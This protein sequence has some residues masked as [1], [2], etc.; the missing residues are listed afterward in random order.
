MIAAPTTPSGGTTA[1]GTAMVRQAVEEERT[2]SL[3]PTRSP[4][5]ATE[6][7]RTLQKKMGASAAY[8]NRAVKEMASNILNEAPDTG[9][10]Q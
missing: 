2:R 9:R 6:A 5:P 4:Q 3:E 8:A 1:E 10:K 7:A